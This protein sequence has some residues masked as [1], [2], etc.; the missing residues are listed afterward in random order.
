M[1][2]DRPLVV[3]IDGPSGSGKSTVARGVAA[4]LSLPVLDTGAMY[5]AVTLAVLEA[6]ADLHDEN[7]CAEIARTRDVR[8]ELGVTTLDGRDVSAAIRGPEVT[9][10]VSAVS[11]HPSV[12]A[13][14]VARQREWVA[15][16][17]G[18]VVEGRDIGTVV[19]PEAA[20][21]VFLT[22]DDAE[23]ARRRQRDENAAAR[24]VDLDEVRARLE[25][26]DALDSQR[27]VS[28]L[29]AADDA[30]LIDTTALDVDTVVA[31]IVARARAAE[32]GS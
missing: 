11:A 12:R 31:D 25:R 7:A 28:P 13:V 24:A 2:S 29:R 3:A 32:V 4:Q 26:R 23:R 9:A 21:K 18:A 22:A 16:R 1:T 17:R 27:A 19:F 14:L 15:A 5:R 10:A 6:G 20:V 30:L 8:V